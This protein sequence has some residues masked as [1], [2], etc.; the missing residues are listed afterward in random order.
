[1]NRIDQRFADLQ[2]R[3][4][5]AFIPYITAGDPTLAQTEQIVLELDRAGADIVEFGVPYTDPLADGPVNQEAAARALKHHVRLADILALVKRLRTK[6]QIPILLFTY[7]NPVLAYGIERLAEDSADAGV[8]GILCVDLPPE[9]AAEYEAAFRKHDLCTV[10]LL[11]PTSTPD[12]VDLVAKHSNGFIYYVSRTGTTGERDNVETDV[13][14]MVAKIKTKT[15]LPIAV[16]FG[17]GTPA[18]A[19]E[20]AA[21][22]DGVVV[23]SAIVRLIGELGATPDTALQVGTFVKSL[24]DATKAR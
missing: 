7:Y 10:F 4:E 3:G 11:A 15:Q 5:K 1:V 23:G 20:V 14:G 2:A 19:R 18:Q 16:G 22:G 13:K 17:I 8:D 9:E 21:Y 12:R 6:T 24:A